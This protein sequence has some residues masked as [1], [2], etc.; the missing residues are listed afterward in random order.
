MPVLSFPQIRAWLLPWA[1]APLALLALIFVRAS[2]PLEMWLPMIGST[3]GV[4][5]LAGLVTALCWALVIAILRV[6]PASVRS[7]LLAALAGGFGPAL[8]NLWFG[9]P[10]FSFP[11]FAA[12][13][14]IAAWRVV[15]WRPVAHDAQVAAPTT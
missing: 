7:L 14:A 11:I 10:T 5:V 6:P 8:L 2:P 1:I 4:F 13:G 3:L 15:P 9:S 12:L